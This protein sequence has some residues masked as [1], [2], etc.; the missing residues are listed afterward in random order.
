MVR[1]QELLVVQHVEREGPGL[2]AQVASER[3]LEV[4]ILRPFA[5]IHYRMPC[6]PTRSWRSWEANRPGQLWRSRLS[7][8]KDFGNAPAL[9]RS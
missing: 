3:D 6:G 1:V 5:A 8:A 2:L 7:K 4:R 9:W